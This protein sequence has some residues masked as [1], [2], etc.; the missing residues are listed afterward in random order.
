MTNDG[1]LIFFGLQSVRELVKSALV[2]DH[3]EIPHKVGDFLSYFHLGWRF[4]L[5]RLAATVLDETNSRRNRSHF[6]KV[7]QI[8]KLR[9]VA[10]VRK[11]HVFYQ[12]RHKWQYGWL[13]F[14]S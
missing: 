8:I 3:I 13:H 1:Y 7:H 4:G 10:H 12:E 5:E 11:C 14:S 9:F 6:L 2:V